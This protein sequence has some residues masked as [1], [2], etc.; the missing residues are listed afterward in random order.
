M[1]W[2]SKRARG[3]VEDDEFDGEGGR[4]PWI[5]R[6]AATVC[7]G[8]ERERAREKRGRVRGSR[9]RGV[10]SSRASREEGRAGW[11]ASRWR[12][13]RARE[14]EGET[15]ESEREQG[16]RRGV[17][18]GVARGGAGWLAGEQVAWGGGRARA[19]ATLPSLCRDE[20]DRG[21][22]WAGGRQ[23]GREGG[24]GAA[25]RARVG[26]APV[27]LSGRKTTEEGARWAGLASWAGCWLG[28]PAGWAAQWRSPG[29]L[30]PLLI[31]FLF[32]NF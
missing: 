30:L 5:R 32:S 8:R 14:S 31:F 26:H 29:K 24:G 20:D 19:P 28:Q 18:Q 6:T 3:R 25:E 22:R 15:G 27:L 4:S 9:G 12:G 10:A 2:A 17:V 1:Q 23:V 13:A 11:Q 7:F 21:G 16:E